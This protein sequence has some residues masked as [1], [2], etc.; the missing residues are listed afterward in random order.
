MLVARDTARA[1]GYGKRSRDRVRRRQEEPMSLVVMIRLRNG[2]VVCAADKRVVLEDSSTGKVGGTRDDAVK[3][4][5][6]A[7]GVLGVVGTA[8]GV[9]EALRG[10]DKLADEQM[11]P[12][13]ELGHRLRSFYSSKCGPNSE[14][15]PDASLILATT[16]AYRSLLAK[17]DFNPYPASNPVQTFGVTEHA[18]VVYQW[19]AAEPLS[20]LE[21]Q[22]LAALM[23]ERTHDADRNVG[24][25]M[26]MWVVENDGARQLPAEEVRDLME[27]ARSFA[28]SMAKTFRAP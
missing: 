1:S 7:G 26:D 21:A 12:A 28:V 10:T 6:F 13:V 23:I 2:D 3:L 8:D 17:R 22:R 18:D 27:W 20:R 9:E 15:W 25:T 14:C 19:F 16:T 24:P 11:D 4:M 5:P